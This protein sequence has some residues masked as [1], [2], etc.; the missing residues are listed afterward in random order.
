MRMA[1]R[2]SASV[3]NRAGPV[4]LGDVISCLVKLP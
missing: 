3:S 2:T 1:M 4:T